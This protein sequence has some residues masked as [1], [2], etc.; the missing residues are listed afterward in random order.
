MDS[1]RKIAKKKSTPI[2]NDI[3]F[4]AKSTSLIK[5]YSMFGFIGAH[6]CCYFLKTKKEGA[7]TLGS[8]IC[9]KGG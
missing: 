6:K 5:A 7:P 3:L 1:N 4:I 9:K 2:L 8:T